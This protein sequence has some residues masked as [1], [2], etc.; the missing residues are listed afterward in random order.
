MVNFNVKA[1]HPDMAQLLRSFA[2]YRPA[3]RI[4]AL[5]LTAKLS[6]GP[7]AVNVSSLTAKAGDAQF[8]G[9]IK[10][11]LGGARP[12]VILNLTSGAVV[13]DPFLPAQKTAALDAPGFGHP[14][15]MPV[16]FGG[17]PLVNPALHAAATQP[18]QWSR[19]SIDL[20]AL[21]DIDAD[22]AY[23]SPLVQYQHYKLENADIAFKLANG[24]LTADKLTGVLFGGQLNATALATATKRPHLETAFSLDN[25]SVKS[26]TGALTGQPLASGSVTMKSRLQTTGANMAD[27]MSSLSGDGSF[28]MKGVDVSQAQGGS[29]MSGVFGLVS[30]LNQFTG[31][32]GGAKKGDGLADISGSFQMAG[33]IARSRDLKLVSN[34]GNGAAQGAV[35][36]GRWQIDVSGQVQ[37]APNVLT[38]L[39][40]KKTG[41][42]AAQAVPFYVKGRLDA[43]NVRVDTSKLPG[44]ALPVPGVDKLLDKAPKGIGNLLQGVLGGGLQPQDSGQDT[45]GSQEQP[46]PQPQQ[47]QPQ[48]QQQ[49]KQKTIRPEDLL[50]GLLRR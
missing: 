4:G 12:K 1:H 33:G 2:G 7:K 45:T 30:A 9:D 20:S 16:A 40:A 49:Q 5:D 46:A 28:Q 47:Q 21:A 31:A 24:K 42:A 25:M 37:L 32:L 11:A 8:T 27:M 29:A 19:E 43:P 34:I 38:A 48:Q 41:G 17:R 14:G 15:V 13:L 3:G 22:V 44:G 39:L 18:G 10:A 50:K 36:L 35:D 26:A 23:K 6:G